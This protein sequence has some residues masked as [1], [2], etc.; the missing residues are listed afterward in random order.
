M[1]WGGNST[2]ASNPSGVG[3][4]SPKVCA[5]SVDGDTHQ[6]WRAERGYGSAF[7]KAWT[8]EVQSESRPEFNQVDWDAVLDRMIEAF[9]LNDPV[10]A[11]F[12][13]P[14]RQEA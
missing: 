8:V 13:W 6:R 12:D 9:D 3:S 5:A 4:T 2:A 11:G 7:E 1:P 14:R 10:I